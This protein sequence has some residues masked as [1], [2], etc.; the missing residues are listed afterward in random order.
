[1]SFKGLKLETFFLPIKKPVKE[2][3]SN[4]FDENYSFLDLQVVSYVAKKRL[5]LT[6]WLLLSKQ[7]RM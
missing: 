6:I 7:R 5:Y 2:I 3:S 4:Y 1:M